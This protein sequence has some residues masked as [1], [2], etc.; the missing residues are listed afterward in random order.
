[1]LSFCRKAIEEELIELQIMAN[2]NHRLIESSEELAQ[3]ILQITKAIAETPF[4]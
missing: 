2:C 3:L 1:M 4:K